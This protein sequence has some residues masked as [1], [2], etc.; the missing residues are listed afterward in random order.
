MRRAAKR[1]QKPKPHDDDAHND[2]QPPHIP[3]MMKKCT[4]TDSDISSELQ[5]WSATFE[6]SFQILTKA[7]PY[8]SESIATV[9]EKC[10]ALLELCRK[11]TELAVNP[12]TTSEYKTLESKA[13]RNEHELNILKERCRELSDC[14]QR[15]MT[16]KA[17][18]R[19][20]K[21]V[22]SER[23]NRLTSM[24]TEQINEQRQFLAVSPKKKTPKSRTRTAISLLSPSFRAALEQEKQTEKT[25][26]ATGFFD[27]PIEF[28]KQES[29][30]KKSRIRKINAEME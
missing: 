1:K 8:R 16:K 9:E 28:M 10:I 18:P 11:V 26:L 24:L 21:G 23:L 22:I 7:V 30:K 4:Q 20:E 5:R 3:I 25:E 17:D 14:L 13:I 6:D 2:D 27:T 19:G 12:T 15:A 29:T